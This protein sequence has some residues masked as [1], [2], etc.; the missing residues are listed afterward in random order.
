MREIVPWWKCH[1][2]DE[3]MIPVIHL[4]LMEYLQLLVNLVS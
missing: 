3:R 4:Q 1:E 2:T